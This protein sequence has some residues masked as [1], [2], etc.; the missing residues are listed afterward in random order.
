MIRH[1]DQRAIGAARRYQLSCALLGVISLMP[2]CCLAGVGSRSGFCPDFNPQPTPIAKPAKINIAS[3]S[4]GQRDFSPGVV[5]SVVMHTT[6]V[7]L[8]GTIEIFQNRANSVSSH[9]VISPGGD[10]YEMV[11][12]RDQAWHATYY[13]SRSI[14][15]EMVGF[16]GMAST[17]NEKN[18][19]A[20][21]ELLSWI[22][23]AYPE[24]PIV[25]PE[26]NAYDFPNDRYD[27]PGIVAHSQV[28]P[29]NKSDPGRFFPWEDVLADVASRVAAV[30]EPSSLCLMLGMIGALLSRRQR[31]KPFLACAFMRLAGRVTM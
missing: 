11:D 2:S 20:L 21:T 30:P 7:S 13:N 19:A 6:E 29:W 31:G 26:G 15:I 24:I 10:I 27:A 9:F 14:G 5:D 8:R 4:F 1:D 23:T 17:W 12:P 22:V 25:R 3:P 16:A 28:Q 18:L